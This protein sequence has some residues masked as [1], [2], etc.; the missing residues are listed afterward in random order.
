VQ[1]P[2]LNLPPEPQPA[3][4][5]PP[6]SQA[7]VIGP[8][9]APPPPVV[10]VLLNTYNGADLVGETIRSVLSQDL[11]NFE[12]L[13]VDDGSTDGTPETVLA[14]AD[15]RIRFVATPR[16]MGPLAAR[17]Y[18]FAKCRGRYIA[19]IEQDVILL[20]N[21]LARQTAYLDRHQGTVLVGTATARLAGDQRVDSPEP[22]RTTAGFVRWALMVGNPLVWP[23]VMIRRCALEGLGTLGRE[24]RIFAEDF[25]LYHRLARVGTLARIDEVLTLYR[26]HTANA[27]QFYGE[28]MLE[29]A[30]RVLEDAYAPILGERAPRMARLVAVHVGDGAPVPNL[31]TLRQIETM[32]HTATRFIKAHPEVDAM[33]R[34][35]IA[36]ERAAMMQRMVRAALRSGTISALT[37]HREGLLQTAGLETRALL[38]SS[39]IGMVRG[40]QRKKPA[41]YAPWTQAKEH[42]FDFDCLLPG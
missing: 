36:A 37:L 40:T 19:P 41:S 35:L 38:S 11:A 16:S 9:A 31:E 3:C 28:T 27:A 18:G 15:D 12:L 5:L 23:S 20:P 21:R 32:L 26:R 30:A 33:A 25:D 39:A 17:N 14:F 34:L 7:G 42:A 10:S 13:V 4:P 8:R 6:A 2:D 1:L 24:E 29:N 22:L